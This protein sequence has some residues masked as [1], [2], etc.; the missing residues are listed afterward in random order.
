MCRRLLFW[1]N[2][3]VASHPETISQK[4]GHF[5]VKPLLPASL[6]ALLH[7]PNMRGITRLKFTAQVSGDRA[8]S[9]ARKSPKDNLTQLGSSPCI[10]QSSLRW[11]CD[12]LLSVPSPGQP[13]QG[14]EHLSLGRV[15]RRF[16]PVEW[17]VS[18]CPTRTIPFRTRE[19]VW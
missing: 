7:V 15:Q 11:S 1:Y 19:N 17:T 4:V 14:E 9:R 5:A 6:F 3:S 12:S 18:C 13:R 8:V 2:L 16:A 10:S